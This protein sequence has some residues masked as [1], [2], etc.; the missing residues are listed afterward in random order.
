MRL[1]NV[2]IK[3]Y[4]SADS[5]EIPAVGSFNVL[6]GKNNSGKSTILFAIYAFFRCIAGGNV[7]STNPPLG[8]PIDL[9]KN[10]KN[11]PIR[12]TLGFSLD[13][14]ERDGLLRDIATEA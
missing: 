2:Q 9:S 6:I 1:N 4:R 11:Q 7:V 8:R 10:S 3:G 14:A 13:L 12:I 5:V